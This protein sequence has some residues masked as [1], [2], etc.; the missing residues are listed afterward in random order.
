MASTR[1]SRRIRTS[2]LSHGGRQ[3]LALLPDKRSKANPAV[4]N[5]TSWISAGDSEYNGLQADL[6]FHGLDG[7]SGRAVYTYSKNLDD[8]SAWNT[9]VSG[10][11]PAFVS[12]PYNPGLDWG[13]AADDVR[14]IVAINAA[15]DLPFGQG[16]AFFAKATGVGARAAAG[17]SVNAIAELQSGFPFSPQLGYNPTNS[18]DSRNPVRPQV[19]P[20]FTGK[21]YPRTVS[22]YF[23]P[24]AFLPPATGTLGDAGRDSLV[25]PGL[26]ELDTSLLKETAVTERVRLQF[27]AEF[28]NVLNHANFA[29]PNEIVYSSATPDLLA[30]ARA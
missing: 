6:R 15:Y 3:R 28:F 2:R 7:L 30:D 22:E 4:S 20:N 11:T 12:Y 18:G 10:N 5:T 1:F 21:L 19:N 26:A 29:T 8:G 24:N 25:G 17:W 16:K 14:H 9:S 23:N 13:P 27:R